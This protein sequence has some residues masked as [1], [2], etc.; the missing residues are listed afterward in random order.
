[1]K[2]TDYMGNIRAKLLAMNL[3]NEDMGKLTDL[4]TFLS[5]ANIDDS[6]DTSEDNEAFWETMMVYTEGLRDW[7][8]D[9]E[10]FVGT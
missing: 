8:A 6:P 10:T 7:R 1:M 3:S 5:D 4:V 9:Y 2:A